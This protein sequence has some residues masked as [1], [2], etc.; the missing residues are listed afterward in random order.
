MYWVT[1]EIV[2]HVKW[3]ASWYPFS[4]SPC[5]QWWTSGKYVVTKGYQDFLLF[6]TNRVYL[7]TF[8]VYLSILSVIL[9][10]RIQ[11]MVW[12]KT[13]RFPLNRENVLGVTMCQFYDTKYLLYNEMKSKK[14]WCVAVAVGDTVV[15]LKS[16]SVGALKYYKREIPHVSTVVRFQRP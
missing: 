5:T 12:D 14:R 8:F 4:K 9:F 3:M 2:T 6:S 10:F 11:L 15:R 7:W 16:L 1:I 13:H